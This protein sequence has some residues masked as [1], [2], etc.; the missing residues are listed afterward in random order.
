MSK[1]AAR[2]AKIAAAQVHVWLD[3]ELRAA[4]LKKMAESR[5]CTKSAVRK[6]IATDAQIKETVRRVFKEVR[7]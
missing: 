5:A 4:R 6:P 1:Y 2:N 7:G 3:P